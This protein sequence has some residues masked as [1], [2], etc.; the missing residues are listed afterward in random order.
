MVF[1]LRE[2]GRRERLKWLFYLDMSY[3]T[4]V[5]FCLLDIGLQTG[6]PMSHSCYLSLTRA[7]VGNVRGCE[8]YFQ[9]LPIARFEFE[10]FVLQ[11]NCEYAH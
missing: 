9:A 11:T 8:I 7:L 5:S 4:I 1:W 2:K 6:D 10:T 3:V